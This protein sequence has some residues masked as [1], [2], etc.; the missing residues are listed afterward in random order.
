MFSLTSVSPTYQTIESVP[1]RTVETSGVWKRWWMRPR[2]AGI[3]F[4][5]AIDSEVRAVG[6][7][8][9]CVDAAA[10]VSTAMITSLSSGEPS[11][12]VPRSPSAS[13]ESSLAIASGPAN[14]IAA[15]ET[16]T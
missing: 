6:R 11:T 7:I 8:V 9:V 1:M 12:C 3:A 2:I 4:A 15:E 5:R 14:E 13:P 10:E 16:S